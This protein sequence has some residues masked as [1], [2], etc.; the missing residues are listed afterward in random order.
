MTI[1]GEGGEENV[2]L[3]LRTVY[4]DEAH[5]FHHD[6]FIA[7]IG[8]AEL[9][10]QEPELAF[11]DNTPALTWDGYWKLGDTK[12][13]PEFTTVYNPENIAKLRLVLANPDEAGLVSGTLTIKSNAGDQTV[14][15]SGLAGEPKIV[16]TQA[17]LANQGKLVRY[18]PYGTSIMTNLI[19]DTSGKLSFTITGLPRGVDYSRETGRI[20]GVPTVTGSFDVTVA[21]KFVVNGKTYEAEETYTLNVATNSDENLS[22]MNAGEYGYAFK[23]NEDNEELKVASSMSSYTEQVM[24]SEGEYAEFQ[25]LWVDGVE[26]SGVILEEG[27]EIPETWPSG[28][29][30]YAKRGSTVITIRAQVFRSAGRGTHT[31]S[32]EFLSG[33]KVKSTSQNYTSTV[34]ESSSGR[35]SG[36]TRNET[37]TPANTNTNTPVEVK[38]TV[39]NGEATVSALSDNE[40]SRLENQAENGE[41]VLDL[42]AN[43]AATTAAVI[44]TAM[45][46]KLADATGKVDGKADS[47]TIKL[48]NADVTLDDASLAAISD[49]AK[50]GNLKLSVENLAS[51]D[52]TEAQ[53]TALADMEV[54]KIVA[55]DLTAGNKEISDFHGGRIT[56]TLPF[57]VPEGRNAR[58]YT[59]YNI[60][61][62]GEKILHRD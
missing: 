35:S 58:D 26:K 8:D 27:E 38:Y 31:L 1:P 45:I 49:Q 36:T 53:Q 40:I 48:T 37:V 47:V 15:L 30:F 29:D 39:S 61:A 46:E 16:T 18:V 55:V 23:K 24:A 7:N 28:V 56:M 19:G 32:A 4:L 41:I 52:L 20:Y 62:D 51:N 50:E 42:S 21:A 17:E 33:D 11:D 59:A 22:E 43:G 5:N 60:T 14:K 3:P 54:S 13:L 25:K 44:P 10:L 2:V 34:S 12:T 57:S 9:T 6:I